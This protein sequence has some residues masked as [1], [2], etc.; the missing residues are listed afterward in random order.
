MCGS[1][2]V[3]CTLSCIILGVYTDYICVFI[4]IKKLL[5]GVNVYVFITMVLFMIKNKY[6]RR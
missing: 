1:Y 6:A 2:V 4:P 5:Q 3:N